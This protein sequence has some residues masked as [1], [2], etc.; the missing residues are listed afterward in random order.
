MA[1]PCESL[2]GARVHRRETPPGDAPNRREIATH[3][4]RV[5]PQREGGNH[6]VR[7]VEAA[8]GAWIPRGGLS[9]D[10]VERGDHVP[11][12]PRDGGELAAHVERPTRQCQGMNPAIRVGRPLRDLSTGEN[13]G[14]VAAP[15]APDSREITADEP[16]ALP[17]SHGGEDLAVDLGVSQSGCSAAELDWNPAAG[18]RPEV[19]ERPTHVKRVA[20]ARDRGHVRQPQPPQVWI[21]HLWRSRCWRQTRPYD[22][23]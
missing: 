5:T 21:H 9:G 3:V 1:F 7:V 19:A 8:G 14:E 6:P 23:S 16:A 10:D 13:V 22:P 2:S 12:L 15:P 20:R 17:V 4:N 11:R 18:V